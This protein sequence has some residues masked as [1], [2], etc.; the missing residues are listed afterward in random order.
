MV[1]TMAGKPTQFL[2]VG[3]GAAHLETTNKRKISE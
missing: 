3:I 2:K 1:V